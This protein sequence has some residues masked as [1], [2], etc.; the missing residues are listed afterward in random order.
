MRKLYIGLGI[1]AF[2]ALL[3]T[4]TNAQTTSSEEIY[5][6]PSFGNTTGDCD[7]INYPIHPKWRRHLYKFTEEDSTVQGFY[8]GT[9]YFGD[10][11]KANFFDLS[12]TA[13]MPYIS[14]VRVAFNF[15]YSPVSS[16]LDKN[17]ILKVL[18]DDN[19]KP[20]EEITR[21]TVRYG[22]VI[23]S[24]QRVNQTLYPESGPKGSK[25]PVLF[26]I[27]MDKV[28]EIPEDGKFYISA[29]F[30]G[31][32]INRQTKPGINIPGTRND[33]VNVNTAW[34]MTNDG[35]WHSHEELY[36]GD[37]SFKTTLYMFPM[38]SNIVTGCAVMPVQLLSFNANRN[39]QNVTLNWKVTA[40]YSMDSYVI[41]RADNNNKFVAVGTVK[42]VN[43]LKD[44]EY[45]FVDKNAFNNASV[46]QYR[47]R[48]V[49]ADGSSTFSRIISVKSGSIISDV[50]FA[51]P[52]TGAL[53]IQLNLASS[54]KVSFAVYNI[55][56]ALVAQLAP[57]NYNANANRIVLN[58]TANLQAGL[59]I[60]KITA[61]SE[62]SVFKVV[63]H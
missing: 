46:V 6:V 58:N 49:N 54:E 15:A 61:G 41:E 18:R 50:T 30:S 3:S 7:T 28:G 9:S 11:Q 63:K 42:A 2:F 14:A 33:I 39:A 35:Q 29:D 17:I 10:L 59:Y 1:A 60:L 40:E 43:N 22:Y 36:S 19:G 4:T 51:N 55:Q 5:D 48:Q 27:P 52:F 21:G 57:A 62:Q 24:V 38:M 44:I 47:L 25:V 32:T 53:T 56:G 37:S 45:N 20:G 13:R 8:N 16:E 26:T 31:L 12:A 34:T 23:D